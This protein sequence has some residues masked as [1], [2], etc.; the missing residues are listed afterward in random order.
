MPQ[1]DSTSSEIERERQIVELLSRALELK[2]R[3]RRRFLDGACAGDPDLRLE[4]DALLAE[5]TTDGDDF[6]E[7]PAVAGLESV[8]GLAE[9]ESTQ[10]IDTSAVVQSPVPKWVGP[11]RIVGT[12]GQGGMGTVYL[13]EQEEPVRRRAALKILDAI[14][15]QRRLKRFAAE[16]Q[17]L[18]RLHHPNVAS[19][20]E[21]G[22]TDQKH[23]YVAMEPVDGTAVTEWCDERRLPLEQRIELFFGVC[24]GVRHAHEKG[25]LHRDLKP[26]NVLVTEVD[27]RPTAKVIDFGIARALGEPLHSGSKPMTLENQIVG[28][29]AYMCPEVAAGERDVDTRSDVYTLGLLLYE[30]LVGAQPFDI[31]VDLV[32]LLRRVAKE[33]RPALSAR[34]AELDEDSRHRIANER[35]LTG[36]KQ[37]ARRLRGDLDAIMAKALA[38]DPEDRYSS[39][40]DLALDLKRHLEMRPVLVRASS[41]PYRTWS[42]VRR[43]RMMVASGL[44]LVVALVAGIVG[45]AREA[46]RANLEA[47]RATLALSESEAVSEF[48]IGLFEVSDPRQARGESI[49]ARELLDRGAEQLRFQ[50]SDQPLSKARITGTIGGIYSQLGLYERAESLLKAGLAIH[51][52]ELGADH[53]QTVVRI[54]E[55]A[56]V[57]QL[58][59]RYGDAE[60]LYRRA[61]DLLEAAPDG[62]PLEVAEV[63]RGLGRIHL[64]QGRYDQAEPLVERALAV[65]EEAL[66][67]DDPRVAQALDGLGAVYYRQGR[68]DQAE[69]L[70]SRA[71]AIREAAL[72]SDHP[73][74]ATSLNNLGALYRAQGRVDEAEALWNRSLTIREKVLGPDHPYVASSMT[75]LGG[76]YREQG[77]YDEAE[78]L[79]RRALAIKQQ[80][81]EPSHPNVASSLV[82]LADLLQEQGRF[83]EAETLTRE[84]L[85]IRE[86]IFGTEH[87]ETLDLVANLA[88]LLRRLGRYSEAEPLYERA[89]AGLD[90]SS[91]PR[92]ADVAAAARDYSLLLRAT[93]RQ[94]E[95]EA[96]EAWLEREGNARHGRSPRP[97][98]R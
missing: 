48:L 37:M 31:Q 16:C 98:R 46:K 93:G 50:F 22:T 92:D 26:S 55:L 35:S 28:S 95:A 65:T 18:A 12:L 73:S 68:Y 1:Q 86:R 51:E 47:R 81:L 2:G 84:A 43:H 13:G 6:L 97:G 78:P 88:I 74:V 25:I 54:R 39:P 52:A 29:P 38:L 34:Y 33:E 21:V 49:T 66:G 91:P 27:G 72:G 42:F 63:L 17:A 14:H 7:A 94:A 90:P 85:R 75:N 71:L 30:L 4:L 60:E 82:E 11:Y 19:L 24:A 62:E 69:P 58:M 5:E 9:E 15:D 10:K 80:A 89:L 8:T 67:V 83:K 44:L 77:R 70:R 40:A 64:E 79:L 45:T 23:P 59:G 20:Y 96:L 32:T 87:A 41:A 36:P 53:P 56:R 3:D 76:L 61:L 57:Y